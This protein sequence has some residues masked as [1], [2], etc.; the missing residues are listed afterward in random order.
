MRHRDIPEGQPFGEA[1]L[2]AVRETYAAKGRP[3]ASVEA[4]AKVTDMHMFPHITVL[5]MHGNLLMYRVRPTPDNNPDRCIFDMYAF[6]TYAE[7]EERPKWRTRH[8]SD[9]NELAIIAGQDFFSIPR[10]Q[11]GLHSKGITH[12]LMGERQEEEIFS[13]HQELDSYLESGRGT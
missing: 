6:R 3:I 11:K 13:M 12:T 2:Q 8:I 10:I 7:N 5:P 4:L 9:V 1:F